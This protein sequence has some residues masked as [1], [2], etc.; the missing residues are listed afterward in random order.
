[1]NEHDPP[2]QRIPLRVLPDPRRL[3]RIFRNAQEW[4]DQVETEKEAQMNKDEGGKRVDPAPARERMK[5]EGSHPSK[6]IE[7][8][9]LEGKIIELLRTVY[10]PE[11]PVNIYDLGLIYAIDI[12]DDNQVDIRMTLTAP[13]C[14][15]A[16]QLVAEVQSKVQNI[17]EVKR[18][19]VELVWDP[20]WS[21]EMIGEAAKLDL[22]LL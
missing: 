15:V 7:K 1:M 12:S 14:P 21:R 13:A 8:K 18:A 19:D 4:Q 3:E 17:E 16:G 9:L 6:A 20:P 11:L 5:D 22:G 10:D 2:S